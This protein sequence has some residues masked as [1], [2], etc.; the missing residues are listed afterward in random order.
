MKKYGIIKVEIQIKRVIDIGGYFVKREAKIFKG[1]NEKVVKSIEFTKY[2]DGYSEKNSQ[3][4]TIFHYEVS[5]ESGIF[6]NNTG[7]CKITLTSEKP[8]Y[9][10]IEVFNFLH[11]KVIPLLYVLDVLGYDFF[12]D[13]EAWKGKLKADDDFSSK[14]HE[15]LSYFKPI[16]KEEYEIGMSKH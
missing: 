4:E 6:Y 1:L 15:Y 12:K 2:K 10:N 13:E 14:V 7:F 11:E 16:S 5:K 9:K 3:I 8:I